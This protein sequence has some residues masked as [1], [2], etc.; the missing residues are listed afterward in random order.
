M[1]SLGQ[2]CCDRPEVHMATMAHV[3]SSGSSAA[4]DVLE[5]DKNE[6]SME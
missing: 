2:L 5:E 3:A 1:Q 6:A 4:R